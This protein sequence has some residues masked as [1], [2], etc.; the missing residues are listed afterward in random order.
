MGYGCGLFNVG[1]L[2]LMIDTLVPDGSSTYVEG[3]GDA[4]E[5][6]DPWVWILVVSMMGVGWYCEVSMGE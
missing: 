5:R 1:A 2:G 3:V 6:L 4:A